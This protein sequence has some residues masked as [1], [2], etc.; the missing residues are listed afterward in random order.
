MPEIDKDE[1]KEF[2][3][4][5]HE[6]LLNARQP[7]EPFWDEI[8]QY[9]MPRA[10][11]I[12]TRSNVP[13][14]LDE[15]YDSTGAY[16]N[17]VLANGRLSWMTPPES[18][19]F[20]YDPPYYLKGDDAAEQW[21]K[22]CTEQV[23]LQLAV[24]NFYN[25]VHE[26]YFDVGGF[27]TG[28]IWCEPGRNMPLLCRKLD[29]GTYCLAENDEGFVDTLS[30]EFEL[31]ARQAVQWFGLD[32]LSD[33]IQKAYTGGQGPNAQ[34]SR[35]LDQKFW[36]RHLVYPRVEE[37]RD[38]EK[39]D[40][41]NKPIASVYTEK[42]GK[43]IVKIGGY[44]EQPFFASRYLK[45][46]ESDP[47]GW[48]PAAIALPD[49][50]Q[51]NFLVKQSDALAEVSA[52]PR[53]LIPEFYKGEIDLRANGITYYDSSNANALPR[54]WL[55]QGKYDIALERAEEKRKNIRNAFHTDLFKMFEGLDKE[56][57]AREVMERSA[58]KL[59]IFSPTFV[60]M[61]T[62]FYNPFLLRAFRIC[63]LSGLFPP[64]PKGV[65]GRDQMGVSI[66]EPEITYSSRIAL[67]I[68]ALE[69]AS[70]AHVVE[71]QAPIMQVRPDVLDNYN[72]DQISRDTA[73]NAG[74]PA[75]WL[76][77]LELVNA[78][79]K[80]RAEQMQAQQQQAQVAQ[81]A[82]SAAKVGSIKQDS[83]AG[84]AI[85]GLLPAA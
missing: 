46:F 9:V 81:M 21:Y 44:T 48:G 54:E 53:I 24:G 41:E 68:K 26:F 1:L 42:E 60:R 17:I 6:E 77:D 71:T 4:C 35:K 7:W 18:R 33:K 73:R 14:T 31:T 8:G 69:N 13:E 61:Q 58:E 85:S 28:V 20:S 80:S 67:A 10:K 38:P 15:I 5:R 19:W 32:N 84:A 63:M 11:K 83:L 34:K 50:R 65:I 78:I 2:V 74:L 27:G 55:T 66:E 37:E 57:T 76:N 29:L 16:C 64:P 72:L 22:I 43:H 82:E 36:F 39:F 3:H 79:R 70:F 25:E 62:E 59:N 52:F 40:P 51:L 75:R 45:W 49:M 12:F 30:R 56:M 23:Q 47:Y